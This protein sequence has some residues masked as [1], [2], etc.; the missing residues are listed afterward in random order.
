MKRLILS[1]LAAFILI[2]S[3]TAVAFQPG[4]TSVSS[5]VSTTSGTGPCLYGRTSAVDGCYSSFSQD[6]TG[7]DLTLPSGVSL[8][9]T[10]AANQIY[11]LT[12]AT[13]GQHLYLCETANT[14]VQQGGTSSSP[15]F[16]IYRDNFNRADG[17]VGANWLT[18]T[19]YSAAT[20]TSSQVTGTSGG[21]A[22]SIYNG[23]LAAKQYA[24]LQD[25]NFSASM[26]VAGVLV[27]YDDSLDTGYYG[28]CQYN[29]GSLELGLYRVNAGVGTLLGTK[30]TAQ[31]A[32]VT[33]IRLTITAGG[34][35]SFDTYNGSWVVG[36]RTYTDATITSGK[37]GFQ[38]KGNLIR[39]DNFEGGEW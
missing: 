13:T 20:I 15:T 2:A 29:A 12:T 22:Q 19:G 37:T 33:K 21:Y 1:I 34:A 5:G 16:T 24:M 17:T 8:P 39:A 6:F 14:W 30:L 3:N 9:G 27:H 4:G 36:R 18:T 7:N 31:A 23:G 35:L 25:I 26:S 10:C 11:S 38:L 32:D 28:Y